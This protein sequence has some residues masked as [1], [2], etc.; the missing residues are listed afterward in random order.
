V[1]RDALAVGFRR[2]LTRTLAD[3][4]RG[5]VLPCE[6]SAPPG[7]DRGSAPVGRRDLL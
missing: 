5:A 1:G 3:A 4:P 2:G 7:A 6:L